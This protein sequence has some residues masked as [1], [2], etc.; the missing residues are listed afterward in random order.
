MAD[1]TSFR[2][3]VE[4]SL[5]GIVIHQDS[6]IVYA[7]PAAERIYRHEPGGMVGI[8]PYLLLVPSE[9]V[10]A[11]RLARRRLAGEAIPDR[12]MFR[13]LRH[14]GVEIDVEMVG[15]LIE[16]D[17]APAVAF[18]VNDVTEHNQAVAQRE[19]TEQL[20]RACDCHCLS[21]PL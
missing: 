15:F 21:L 2:A 10:R 17:G 7:N 20:L 9:R 14:D 4:Q 16:W 1:S 3:I 6:R 5:D 18:S 19:E 12:M 8:E 11:Q 13:A